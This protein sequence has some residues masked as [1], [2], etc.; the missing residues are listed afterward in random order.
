MQQEYLRSVEVE[1]GTFIIG[2]LS[3]DE[4]AVFDEKP[5]LYHELFEK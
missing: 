1:A 5:C 4:M 2:V 3:D